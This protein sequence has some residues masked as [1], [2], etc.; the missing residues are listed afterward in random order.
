MTLV[1]DKDRHLKEGR[2]RPRYN[3]PEEAKMYLR[4]Y[5]VS[6]VCLFFFFVLFFA[7]TVGVARAEYPDKPITLIVP[8]AP[9]GASD[10]T[11]RTL[12][13]TMSDELKQPVV[14]VNRPCASGVVGTRRWSAPFRMATRS[15]LILTRR[16]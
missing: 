3:Q 9:G 16:L 11:P 8:W 10:I 7:L 4:K 12:L 2:A 1:S 14:I 5:H 6:F 15:E 13:K